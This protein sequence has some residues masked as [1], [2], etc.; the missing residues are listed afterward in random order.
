MAG[1]FIYSRSDTADDL[2]GD[3]NAN[4]ILGMDGNDTLD[5]DAGNDVLVGGL[6]NDTMTG[7]AGNDVFDFNVLD[8]DAT[9]DEITDFIKGEDVLDLRDII[10][11]APGETS[12]NWP[13]GTKNM[14]PTLSVSPRLRCHSQPILLQL[15]H[16]PD[17]TYISVKYVW[18]MVLVLSLRLPAT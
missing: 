5:G 10:D 4:L 14:A 8:V 13:T 2:D 7:G 11:L 17:T 12:N 15:A 1:F 18:Q 3:E 16:P 9:T 6:G